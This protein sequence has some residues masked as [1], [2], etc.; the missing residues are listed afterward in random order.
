MGIGQPINSL[1]HALLTLFSLVVGLDIHKSLACANF[2]IDS[3]L[4]CKKSS[5]I[6]YLKIEAIGFHC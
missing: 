1:N 2:T 5:R 3:F 6:S 4:Q